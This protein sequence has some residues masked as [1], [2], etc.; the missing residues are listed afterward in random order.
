MEKR[1]TK[2]LKEN[3]LMYICLGNAVTTNVVRAIGERLC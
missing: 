2:K 3:T 1:I